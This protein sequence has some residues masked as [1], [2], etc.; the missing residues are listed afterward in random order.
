MSRFA[1]LKDVVTLQLKAEKC[2][3]CGVCLQVCP[4][5]VFSMDYDQVR[6]ENRDACME[7][8]A[9]AQNCFAEALLVETGVGC[10]AA[11]INAALGRTEGVCCDISDQRSSCC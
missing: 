6:I 7:C 3:G 10:A 8:G 11:V 4:H 2:V 5:A 9:C 1:Y